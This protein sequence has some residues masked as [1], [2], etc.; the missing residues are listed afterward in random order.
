[1]KNLEK[2]QKERQQKSYQNEVNV[3]TPV[4]SNI[5]T[6]KNMDKKDDDW[7]ECIKSIFT[8]DENQKN[9]KIVE[10]GKNNKKKKKKKKNKNV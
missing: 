2:K 6:T 10:G 1:M 3:K 4:K 7:D 5:T 8:K 9:E